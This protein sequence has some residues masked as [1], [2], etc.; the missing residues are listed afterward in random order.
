MYFKSMGLKSLCLAAVVALAAAC[1]T[2]QDQSAASSGQ[3]GA[4]QATTSTTAT[5]TPATPAGPTP[6]SQADLV[7]SVGDRVFFDFDKYELKPQARNTVERWAGWLKR[8]PQVTVTLEGHADE[9][10]TR[11]YN[12]GLGERRAT[13]ARN[14]LIAL[15]I[16]RN[17]MRTISYGKERPVCTASNEACWSQNRRVVM[18]VGGASS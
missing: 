13:S 14:Y 8:Y 11:E 12:L 7:A 18:M 5:P 17:R 4:R 15:G 3:G 16:D 1:E 10:G 2:A 9:R 6:G